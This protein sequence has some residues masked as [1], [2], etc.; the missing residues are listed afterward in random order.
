MLI[1]LVGQETTLSPTTPS[2]QRD[3]DKQRDILGRFAMSPTVAFPLIVRRRLFFLSP[4][5][6]HTRLL[7]A[8]LF[9]YYSLIVN[10]AGMR[11]VSLITDALQGG[12]GRVKATTEVAGR[13]NQSGTGN[14]GIST[15][16]A[17]SSHTHFDWPIHRSPDALH[18]TPGTRRRASEKGL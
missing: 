14:P 8:H 7:R 5:K 15:A 11:N 16:A 17:L 9:H 3:R 6:T 10:Y 13:S 12:C 18:N 4:R 1:A 2:P